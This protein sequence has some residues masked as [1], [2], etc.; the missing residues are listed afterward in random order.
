MIS[1]KKTRA[2]ITL[3]CWYLVKPVRGDILAPARCIYASTKTSKVSEHIIQIA[4]QANLLLN[5]NLPD[6]TS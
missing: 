3:A 6:F 5:E 1:K 2:R 4:G